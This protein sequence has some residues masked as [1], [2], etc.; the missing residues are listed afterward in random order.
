MSVL[1]QA[2]LVLRNMHKLLT[3]NNLLWKTPQYFID[4]ER[5]NSRLIRLQVRVLSDEEW[6]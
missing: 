1:R 4:Y 5:F 2:Y 6:K 3:I